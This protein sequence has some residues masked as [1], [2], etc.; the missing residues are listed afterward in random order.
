MIKWLLVLLVPSMGSAFTLTQAE[1]VTGFEDHNVNIYYNP[2]NCPSDIGDD[3]QAT[4][5]VWSNVPTSS[6]DLK[7]VGTTTAT[8]ASLR[9]FS[10]PEA[11]VIACSNN[12]SVDSA[13]SSDTGGCTGSC[14]DAV[15]GGSRQQI[16]VNGVIQK[17]IVILNV[18]SGALANYSA[19]TQVTKRTIL[20]HEIG[21]A[22]GLGHSSVEA[23]LMNYSKGGSQYLT[24]HQDDIDGISYLYPSDTLYG[25]GSI[26]N[27][28]DDNSQGGIWLLLALP[29]L[30]WFGLATK[31]LISNLPGPKIIRLFS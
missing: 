29:L 23:A 6:L 24:L 9:Y 26:R 7:V 12:F 8:A 27:P 2:T 22:L 5:Q 11:F 25:C 17:S 1:F 10:Q 15:S 14:L 19:Q 4:A 13:N 30:L 18:N 20:A 28:G 21:H 16:L 3:L 31:S